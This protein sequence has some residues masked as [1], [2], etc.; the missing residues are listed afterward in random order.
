M[1]T[2]YGFFNIGSA[3]LYI[4]RIAIFVHWLLTLFNAH[5]AVVR[6][7]DTFTEPFLSPFRRLSMTLMER[8]GVPLDFSYVFALIGLTI[9]ERLW[10]MLYRFLR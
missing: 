10:Q 8:T 3:F 1:P 7:L 2:L 6:W 9:V 4:L 5:N